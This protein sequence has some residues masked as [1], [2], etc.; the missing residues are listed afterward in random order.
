MSLVPCATRIMNE[1]YD[2]QRV[3]RPWYVGRDALVSSRHGAS[4]TTT[5]PLDICPSAFKLK[6]VHCRRLSS[7]PSHRRIPGPAPPGPNTT[8]Q[9]V[10]GAD[11]ERRLVCGLLSP[12]DDD[13][14]SSS[15]GGLLV[16]RLLVLLTSFVVFRLSPTRSH[17]SLR[18]RPRHIWTR[19]HRL[20]TV[21]VVSESESAADEYAPP[22]SDAF[23]LPSESNPTAASPSVPSP[24]SPP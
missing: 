24:R 9:V 2:C 3:R 15:V 16:L 7:R 10:I 18:P 19:D 21:R 4:L 23:C 14:R 11:V 5:D 20:V 1:S 8:W 17:K 6:F 22:L 12:P 13:L